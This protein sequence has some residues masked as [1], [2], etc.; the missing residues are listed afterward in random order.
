MKQNFE[1]RTETTQKSLDFLTGEI[2]KQQQKV[3]DS[4]RAMADYRE[5]NNALSLADRQNTVVASLNQLN[6]Q[7]TRAKTER[8]QKEAQYKQV[9][10]LP[11][12]SCARGDSGHYGA[13]RTC[14]RFARGSPSCAGSRSP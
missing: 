12:P 14:R 2:G 4:E 1:L 7:F 11:P 6:D 9:E 13:A 5:N 8:I 3:E 10:G